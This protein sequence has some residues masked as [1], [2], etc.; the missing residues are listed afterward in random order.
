MYKTKSFPLNKEGRD[1]VVG[2]IHGH[3][4]LLTSA[5][6]KLNFNTDLDRIFSVGDLIDRGPD[7]EDVLNWL[8]EPWFHA[9][10]GNHEQMLIDC[11]SGHGDIPRHIRNGGAWLYT[12]QPA[13]QHEL[14]KSLQELPLIIEVN[15]AS[16]RTIGIVHAEAPIS[17]HHDGWQEAKDAITGKL[18]EQNQQ[19]ALKT[20]LYAREKIERQDHTPIKGINQL[21]VGHSTVSSVTRLGNVIY[22]DTGCSFSDGALSLVEIKTET[23][24]DISMTQ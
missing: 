20:A 11:I 21:Y 9:V 10:R 16:D 8:K 19:L 18:G 13:T 3:F 6:N 15:L 24:T 4:K 2:D 23:I 12:L 14:L 1:F 22:T 5:L 17:R 7:S